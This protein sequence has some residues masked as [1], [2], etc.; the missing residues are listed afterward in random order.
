LHENPLTGAVGADQVE[1]ARAFGGGVFGMAVV[2]VETGSVG[3]HPVRAGLG[4]ASPNLPLV[5]P[6]VLGVYIQLVSIEAAQV[7]P[8]RLRGVIPPNESRIRAGSDEARG[9]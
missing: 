7:P 1:E 4:F 2:V 5:P 9:V 3:E 6:G 8:W